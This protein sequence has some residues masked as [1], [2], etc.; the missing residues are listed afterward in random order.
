MNKQE[1]FLVCLAEEA[2][3][4]AL[5]VGQASHKALR[6][7]L[8]DGY[9]GTGRTNRGDI[10]QEV[11]DLMGVLELMQENGMELTGLFD[12]A[13]IDAK[14]EKV[15]KWMKYAEERGCLSNL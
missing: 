11:N 14:K 1:H 6:F 5:A 3:E 15:R 12:R 9:P 2:G 8:D 7:G 10:V 13:A 4:I